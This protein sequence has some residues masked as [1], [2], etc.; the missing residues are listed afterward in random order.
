MDKKIKVLIADDHR[1][2]RQGLRALLHQYENIEVL[3]EAEN[4]RDAVQLA[5][6][7]C[8]DVILM[9]ISMPLLNG[10]EATCQIQRDCPHVKVIALSVH[11]DEEII[12]KMLAAGAMGYITKDAHTEELIQAIVSVHEG[13]M[14]LSPVI[15]RLVVEDFLR[16]ADIQNGSPDKLTPREREVLQLI[17]EGHQNKSIAKILQ[18]SIKT[19]RAHRN[20]IMQKLDLHSQGD[21]IRYAIQKKIV[22]I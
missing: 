13:E 4:G 14:A 2:V 10:L 6:E 19:V 7:I 11:D 18:I 16:W 17:A 21:L 9:D 22:E 12:R 3:G 20:N 1:I 8:P 15:T 5:K